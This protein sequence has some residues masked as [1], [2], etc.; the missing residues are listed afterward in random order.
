L[1]RLRENALGH[2]PHDVKALRY[3]L[4]ALLAAFAILQINDPD[5]LVWVVAYGLAAF[6]VAA[7]PEW[8]PRRKLSWLTG[9]V[10][11]TL[12]LT[13][14]PGFA[15]Y[16]LSGEPSMILAEMSPDMPYVEPAREFLG[17]V[18]AGSALV[19]MRYR[20]PSP[21]AVPHA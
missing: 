1:R 11:L 6:C 3:S 12:G 7:P 16:L 14:F 13:S 18:I 9:G 4:S 2:Q 21:D 10:L 20:R 15:G 19:G 8:K 5:P 17:I